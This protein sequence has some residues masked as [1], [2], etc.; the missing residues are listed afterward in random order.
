MA[1]LS[2]DV[3]LEVAERLALAGG[4]RA[5]R[6]VCRAWRERLRGLPRAE[7]WVWRAANLV[8]AD[9]HGLGLGDG[10]LR[11]KFAMVVD[12]AERFT[13]KWHFVED[14]PL[15]KGVLWLASCGWAAEARAAA[16]RLGF[17]LA[18]LGPA[19]VRAL[20]V[21]GRAAELWPALAACGTNDHALEGAFRGACERGRLGLAR[22]I[23]ARHPVAAPKIANHDDS[24]AFRMACA[25]G[26]ME[27]ARWLHGTFGPGPA[28][29]YAVYLDALCRFLAIAAHDLRGGAAAKGAWLAGL[30]G[31]TNQNN[32]DNY[33]VMQVY[34]HLE[35]TGGGPEALGALL[36]AHEPQLRRLLFVVE[37]SGDEVDLSNFLEEADFMDEYYGDHV[38]WS[39][40]TGKHS[41]K[42][43]F[44]LE[45]VS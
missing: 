35:S 14:G 18:G 23:A 13:H 44:R 26:H 10:G 3:Q 19:A 4:E 45:D 1:N 2:F 15:V 27:T 37:E 5:A 9:M 33:K 38:G 11:A 36:A 24:Y 41:W 22:E 39:A 30:L 21:S 42:I 32:L 12:G 31:P 34:A 6:L 43:P 20:A 17:S 25:N 29:N 40:A 28:D 8:V 16:A 7:A